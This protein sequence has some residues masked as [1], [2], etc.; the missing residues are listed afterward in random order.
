MLFL[1]TFQGYFVITPMRCS[2]GRG[3]ILVNR[4]WVPMSYYKQDVPWSRPTGTV[5]VVGV[6]TKTERTYGRL[7]I[8]R[9]F[10]VLIMYIICM[11]RSEIVCVISPVNPVL[12]CSKS[13]H[14]P[15]SRNSSR[16]STIRG[17]QRLCFG[18]IG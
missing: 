7:F 17:I 18:W 12:L 8:I 4:G 6:E 1:S 2:D 9:F 10:R 11:C 13:S 16:L 3:T 15:Q 14:H 5:A